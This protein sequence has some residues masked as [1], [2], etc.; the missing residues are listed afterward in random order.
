MADTTKTETLETGVQTKLKTFEKEWI[1][2][3]TIIPAVIL[4]G[5]TAFF[6]HKKGVK[7][8]KLGLFIGGAAVVGALL[9]VFVI[10]PYIQPMFMK[11][12]KLNL[13]S[14]GGSAPTQSATLET[15]K[16]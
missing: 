11:K 9:D 3:G 13:P 7:G 5:A 16:V 2:A 4:G 10:K 12:E 15:G 14:S 8:V 1:N 6:A